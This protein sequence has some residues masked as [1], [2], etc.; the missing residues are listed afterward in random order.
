MKVIRIRRGAE[1]ESCQPGRP[2]CIP[3]ASW[4]PSPPALRLRGS[5]GRGSPTAP[6]ASRRGQRRSERLGSLGGAGRGR[7]Q[8][9]A[10]GLGGWSRG[11]LNTNCKDQDRRLGVQG[12][13][14]KLG[15]RLRAELPFG[16]GRGR[17][18]AELNVSQ[19]APHARPAHPGGPG[20]ARAS[21]RVRSHPPSALCALFQALSAA[22]RPPG[23]QPV[24]SG[25]VT[26]VHSLGGGGRSSRTAADWCLPLPHPSRPTPASILLGSSLT[27]PATFFLRRKE[28]LESSSLKHRSWLE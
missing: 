2:H 24:F 8:S 5:A 28:P 23:S 7:P 22:G 14:P 12:T 6:G 20:R 3:S 18:P 1:G 13:L 17:G 26:R 15:A 11:G 27:S 16:L 25:A 21:A 4:P 19:R 9:P 10:K